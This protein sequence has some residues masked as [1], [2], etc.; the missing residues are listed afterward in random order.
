M[1][2]NI[3]KLEK[4]IDLYRKTLRKLQECRAMMQDPILAEDEDTYSIDHQIA[5]L[6]TGMYWV[7]KE[8]E[9]IKFINTF[10]AAFGPMTSDNLIV[11]A[12]EAGMD[13]DFCDLVQAVMQS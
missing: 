2:K 6:Q 8:I 10:A 7:Q 3:N 13:H 11:L 12:E 1:I 9:A 5:E 4:K